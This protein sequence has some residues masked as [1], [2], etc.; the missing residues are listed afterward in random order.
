M[1]SGFQPSEVERL[2]SVSP[3]RLPLTKSGFQAKPDACPLR[4]EDA[5]ALFPSAR[6][7]EAALAGLLLRIGCWTE[8][9]TV[10]QNV[11]TPEGS[12]WHAIIHRMEPDSANASYWFQRTGNHPI[13]PELLARAAEILKRNGPAN[14][15]L[16]TAWDPFLFVGWCDEAQQTRGQAEATTTE[17]QNAEW[18][19]LFDWCA[20]VKHSAKA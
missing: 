18:H 3:P 11:N 10:A 1:R 9:H 2:L 7:S 17:I 16:K 4:S 14:W 5:S 19:L 13:F 8:S 6:H 20:A 12:Y 15:Q